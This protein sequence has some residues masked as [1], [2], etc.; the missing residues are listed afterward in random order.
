[1]IC[2]LFDM[3]LSPTLSHARGERERTN[4]PRPSPVEGEGVQYLSLYGRGRRSR[5]RAT[6][7]PLRERVSP[8]AFSTTPACCRTGRTP[9]PLC[10]GRTRVRAGEGFCF[11]RARRSV[12]RLSRQISSAHFLV[13][14]PA[15]LVDST[16]A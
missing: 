5:V 7:L 15:P 11:L 9:A 6:P 10:A 1:M 8:D 13:V 3:P 2:E 14:L 16:T 12:P 4:S